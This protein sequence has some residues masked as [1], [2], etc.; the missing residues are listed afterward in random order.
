MQCMQRGGKCTKSA[1]PSSGG[2]GSGQEPRE[3]NGGGDSWPVSWEIIKNK[4]EKLNW[5]TSCNLIFTTTPLNRYYES[6]L[7]EHFK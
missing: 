6:H 7:R 3:A 4:Q 2:P 1:L 5:N